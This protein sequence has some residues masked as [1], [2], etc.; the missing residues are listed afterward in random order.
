MLFG[1]SASINPLGPPASA[2]T[3][4]QAS[5]PSI[6]AYPDPDCT[7]LRLAIARTHQLAPA[8]IL[9]GNGAAELLTWASRDLA[10]CAQTRY[11]VPGFA[12]YQRAL[13]AFGAAS[14]PDSLK[15]PDCLLPDF[16]RGDRPPQQCGLLLNNPH[17]PTGRLWSA[18]QLQPLLAQFALVVV[19]EAFMDF[20][21]P[22]QQESLI[23]QITTR[24][25]LVILRSLTKFYSLPG[26]RLGYAIAHPDRLKRWQGWRD[27][28]SV[29]SLATAAGIAALRDTDFQAQTWHWLPTARQ[30]LMAGLQALPGLTPLA[31]AANFLLVATEYSSSALQAILLKKHQI[32]IRDCLS[33]PELGDRYFRVAVRTETEN[34][35]LLSGLR[36]ILAD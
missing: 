23:A 12:D 3:A 22:E 15:L 28:W 33:F 26:L 32:L 27:P 19:D 31:G 30:Q 13:S 34:Q 21:P 29:N 17:N 4:L 14:Q 24:Q 5:L 9:P 11:L 2:L 20:L 6:T 1:F 36:A 18:A 25:N 16:T 10:A 7:A 35:R 8:W